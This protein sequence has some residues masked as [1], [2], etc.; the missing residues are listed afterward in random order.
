MD[1]LIEGETMLDWEEDDSG[2][3]WEVDSEKSTI[4]SYDANESKEKLSTIRDNLFE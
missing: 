3:I 2:N 4:D 1:T